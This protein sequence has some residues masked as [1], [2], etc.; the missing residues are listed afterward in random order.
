MLTITISSSILKLLIVNIEGQMEAELIELLITELNITRMA[1]GQLICN[2]ER[3]YESVPPKTVAESWM[4][5]APE[6]SKEEW[7]AGTASLIHHFRVTPSAGAA[8]ALA[9]LSP[10]NT[11]HAENSRIFRRIH[12]RRGRHKNSEVFELG[13]D[14]L[15]RQ[16]GVT[17][18][19]SSEMQFPRCD[20]EGVCV[21][22]YKRETWKSIFLRVIKWPQQQEKASATR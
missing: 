1:M 8:Q 18:P 22:S 10:T 13:K 9:I 21:D 11:S 17:S 2:N 14:I 20:K 12:N 5:R 7:I 6:F 15:K 3:K 4:A 16:Y 19:V